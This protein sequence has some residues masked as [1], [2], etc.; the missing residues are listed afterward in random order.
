MG[1]ISVK[2]GEQKAEAYGEF[3]ADF[4]EHMCVTTLIRRNSTIGHFAFCVLSLRHCSETSCLGEN[5][6]Y[7]V[8]FESIPTGVAN[9]FSPLIRT[10]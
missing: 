1:T 3:S 6:Q 7:S 8:L 2:L 4:F 5:Q 10:V 9:R